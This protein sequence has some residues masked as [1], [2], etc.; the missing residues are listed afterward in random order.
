MTDNTVQVYSIY[1]HAPAAKIWQAITT[2]E[3]T[4]RWGYGGEVEYDLQPG[5]TYKN[6]TTEEMCVRHGPGGYRG[7]RNHRRG[8]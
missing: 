5:G 2:S 3:Y 1:I 6:F 4:T 8:V 7:E